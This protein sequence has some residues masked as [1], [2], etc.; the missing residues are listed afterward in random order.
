MSYMIIKVILVLVCASLDRLFVQ[1]KIYYIL[2]PP[3]HL[4]RTTF[5]FELFHSKCRLS[6]F[7]KKHL[8]KKCGS[9]HFSTLYTLFIVP[10]RKWTLWMGRSIIFLYFQ[11][12]YMVCFPPKIISC[13]PTSVY[14]HSSSTR[15]AITH[16]FK[17]LLQKYIIRAWFEICSYTNSLYSIFNYSGSC[18]MVCC[19]RYHPTIPYF[20]ISID[21]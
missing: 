12:H 7:G 20:N 16:L 14:R 19:A 3:S 9:Y 17:T 21:M 5:L 11:H 15:T 10:K 18:L 4:K 13:S 8:F 2:V 6:F 1:N